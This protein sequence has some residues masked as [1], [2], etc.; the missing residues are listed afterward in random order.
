[1]ASGFRPNSVIPNINIETPD[2]SM[3]SKAAV[4]VQGRYLEGFNRYKSTITSLLNANIRSADNMKFRSQYFK[5]ID[6][7]LNNLGGIDFSN[8]SNVSVADNLME[9]LIKDPEFIADLQTTMMQSAERGKMDSVRMSSDEKTRSQYNP[10]MEAAMSYH[11]KDM[12]NAKRGDGSIFKVGVQRF[13]PFAN[14][15]SILEKAANDAKLEIKLDHLS[16]SYI[17]TD[18]NGRMA[19]PSFTQWARAQLGS[20]YDEQL[21]VTGKVNVRRQVDGLLEGNPKLTKEEAYQQIASNY[22]LGIYSNYKEYQS[23][24]SG[25]LLSV[26]KEI[27]AMMSQWRNKI[28]KGSEAEARYNA[29]KQMKAQY[30][31]ELGDMQ[32]NDPG[33]EDDMKTAFNQFM[34][35]PEYA[36]LPMMKDDITRQ[37]ATGYAMSKVGREIKANEVAMQETKFKWDEMMNDKKFK[38]DVYKIGYKSDLDFKHDLALA[39]A[40]KEVS[41][42]AIQQDSSERS[43]VVDPHDIY[44]AEKEQYKRDAI[45]NYFDSDVLSVAANYA[46]GKLNYSDLSESLIEV[47]TNLNMYKGDNMKNA[48]LQFKESYAKVLQY[49]QK[50]NPNLKSIDSVY[51]IMKTISKG[52]GEFRGDPKRY[53]DASEKLEEGIMA[54]N[55]YSDMSNAYNRKAQDWTKTSINSSKYW[56]VDERGNKIMS[57]NLS[58]AEKEIFYKAT[59]PDYEKT[60]KNKTAPM[61]SRFSWTGDEKKFNYGAI[62]EVIETAEYA[63][64]STGEEDG[65]TENPTIMSADEIRKKVAGAGG[66]LQTYFNPNNM[67]ATKHFIGNKEY[68]KVTIPVKADS[69][70]E[71]KIL[72]DVQGGAVSFYIPADKA[73]GLWQSKSMYKNP[74]GGGIVKPSYPELVNIPG[75]LF[76]PSKPSVWIKNGLLKGGSVQFPEWASTYGI[77]DGYLKFDKIKGDLYTQFTV[78]GITN[79]YKI[80]VTMSEF[81]ADPTYQSKKIMESLSKTFNHIK[82]ASY[83]Q[84][85]QEDISHKQN[86]ESNPENY[87]TIEDE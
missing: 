31:K 77:T 73:S 71:G 43:G 10:V 7:Y 59:I 60:Y 82:D 75:V 69:K 67:S 84:R 18:T 51:H 42:D 58:E 48:T 55:Q 3:L 46:P 57:P 33:R 50:I 35:N 24:L 40:K 30:K 17:I 54:F 11:D 68:M 76:A 1:M 37:W 49:L 9:P 25:G 34:S 65:F 13:V 19:V 5:K 2:F 8:P 16:G 86:V 72:G 29:L 39:V 26:D 44:Q 6:N 56:T 22:S 27:K 64:T 74:M 32:S 61:N 21:L 4:S 12:Q 66:E 15:Q 20:N 47:T 41:G 80:P 45:S 28:P 85:T 78:N 62:Q 70:N 87:I 81:L 38:Q 63:S 36:L 53:K 23:S 79:E 14:I 52:V 83:K